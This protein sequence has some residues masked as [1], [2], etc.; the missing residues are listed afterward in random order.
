MYVDDHQIYVK[1]KD[2][3]TIVAKLHVLSLIYGCPRLYK[4]ATLSGNMLNVG[5]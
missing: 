2:V 3:C 4:N 5:E 1:G